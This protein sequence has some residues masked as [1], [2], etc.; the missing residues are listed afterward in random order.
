ME[1]GSGSPDAVGVGS[2]FGSETGS[3]MGLSPREPR[4][5]NMVVEVKVEVASNCVCHGSVLLKMCRVCFDKGRKRRLR[6]RS[7]TT[8]DPDFCGTI[9]QDQHS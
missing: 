2:R 5:S 1:C 3:E 4:S 8:E 9:S 7:V 6:E